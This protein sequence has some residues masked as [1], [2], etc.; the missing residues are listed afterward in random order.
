M[1]DVHNIVNIMQMMLSGHSVP[2]TCCNVAG[3]LHTITLHM[4][5]AEEDTKNQAAILIN[6]CAAMGGVEVIRASLCLCACARA[7]LCVRACVC[8]C[9]Y[10]YIYIYIYACIY[11]C[12]RIV[13]FVM[14]YVF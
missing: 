10:I 7:S 1:F 14:M 9:I 13:A 8:A 12:A 6:N 4:C 2:R 11:V 5:G 3:F